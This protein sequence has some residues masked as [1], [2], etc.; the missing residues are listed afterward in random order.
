[1]AESFFV[2]DETVYLRGEVLGRPGL[3][4]PGEFLYKPPL[5]EYRLRYQEAVGWRERLRVGCEIIAG[6]VKDLHPK[7]QPEQGV[8]LTPEQCE[9]LS[10]DTW[11]DLLNHCLGFVGPK[12]EN[13]LGN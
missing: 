4:P 7:G 1:M 12:V 2:Q 3:S 9:K 8:R 11:N 6:N 13:L 5:P 10:G